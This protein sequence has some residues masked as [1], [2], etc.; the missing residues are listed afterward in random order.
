[1]KANELRIGNYVTHTN[2]N[3]TFTLKVETISNIGIQSINNGGTWLFAFKE[4]KAIE[5]TPQLLEQFGFEKCNDIDAWYSIKILNEWTR[6]LINPKF[7]MAQLSINNH[8]TIIGQRVFADLHQ[9]QNL[10]FA[11]SGHELE[12]KL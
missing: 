2:K 1:M 9:L 7:Y 6:L 12:V 5:L 8:D 11:L 3:G 4:I 10:Y